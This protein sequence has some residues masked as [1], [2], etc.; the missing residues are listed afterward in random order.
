MGAIAI[1]VGIGMIW[2]TKGVKLIQGLLMIGGGL[3]TFLVGYLLDEYL[4]YF[5]IVFGL[6][7]AGILVYVFAVKK[8]FIESLIKGFEVQKGHE[9]SPDIENAVKA[10][11]GGAQTAIS[12]M[13]KKILNK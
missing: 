2:S 11:Q 5:C 8:G 1:L 13:R 9:W 6:V 4:V 10:A 3:S 12:A 7:V